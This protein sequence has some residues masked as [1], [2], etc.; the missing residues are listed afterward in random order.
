MFDTMTLTKITAGLCGSLLI[1]LLGGWVG[2]SLYHTGGGHGGHGED[3]AAS[4]YLI[5]VDTGDGGAEVEEGPTFEEVLASADIA[6]G[7]KV[8]GKCKACHKLE[9][10]ANGTGP[11]LFNVV[12]RDIGSEPGFGYSAT[13]T[14]MDGVWDYGHLDGFLA[15]PK[16]YAPGT[17]M[18]FAGLKKI[19][20]RANLVAY[21]ET[22]K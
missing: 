17:K 22:I 2:E 4:G 16:G 7:E 8:F 12:N 10:G 21:L 13:L 11:T 9:A 14:E 5:E 18:A 1:F 6:K 19:E 15:N 3:S 20:D